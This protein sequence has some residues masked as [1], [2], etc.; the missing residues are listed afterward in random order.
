VKYLLFGALTTA[1]W[2]LVWCMA[3]LIQACS[4][5]ICAKN[6]ST[7]TEVSHSPMWGNGI[8]QNVT[9]GGD[10]GDECKTEK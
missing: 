1:V 9:V 6:W 3:L 10:L 2:T 5:H 4:P 7:S 8:S